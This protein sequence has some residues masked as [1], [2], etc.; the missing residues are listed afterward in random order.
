MKAFEIVCHLEG[1]TQPL[2][3]ISSGDVPANS[4][5][6][7]MG[8]GTL[9]GHYHAPDPHSWRQARRDIHLQA[10]ALGDH[11]IFRPAPGSLSLKRAPAGGP[12][13]AWRSGCSSMLSLGCEQ[14]LAATKTC[15]GTMWTCPCQVCRKSIDTHSLSRHARTC[16]V[17]HAVSLGQSQTMLMHLYVTLPAHRSRSLVRHAIYDAIRA[18]RRY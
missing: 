9:L 11:P 5:F 18:E 12:Q 14:L 15:C 1:L 10:F 16:C 4:I 3:R 8:V 13:Q 17:P 6:D 2:K 7:I